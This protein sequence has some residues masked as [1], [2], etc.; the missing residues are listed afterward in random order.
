[1]KPA[2]EP[3]AA[4]LNVRFDERRW[5]T[6]RWPKAP[7]YRAHLRLY[8]CCLYTLAESGIGLGQ[9]SNRADRGS[10]D[11]HSSANSLALK[12]ATWSWVRPDRAQ[13]DREALAQSLLA[14]LAPRHEAITLPQGSGPTNVR[15]QNRRHWALHFPPNPI[16][17][18]ADPGSHRFRPSI[19]DHGLGELA[20][21]HVVVIINRLRLDIAVMAVRVTPSGA[22][23]HAD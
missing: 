6:G 15:R 2:G 16:R 8:R 12:S 9:S 4:N 22:L 21:S 20:A 14:L 17:T 10:T 19:N 23:A 11:H 7:S 3:Y 18:A 1:M 13:G 5:E